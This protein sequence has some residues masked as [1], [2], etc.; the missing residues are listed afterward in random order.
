MKK[1]T[2]TSTPEP[3][4]VRKAVNVEKLVSLEL[5]EELGNIEY[6]ESRD[7]GTIYR[8]IGITW[9]EILKHDVVGFIGYICLK[10]YITDVVYSCIPY[11]ELGVSTF[12]Q[13]V[14]PNDES[15]YVFYKNV[16]FVDGTQYEDL[17][18]ATPTDVHLVEDQGKLQLQLEHDSEVLSIDEGVN[19]I[20]GRNFGYREVDAIEYSG[21]ITISGSL[22]GVDCEIT[23]KSDS[24]YFNYDFTNF[25]DNTTLNQLTA[26]N[27]STLVFMGSF[28][29][30]D[31]GA[32]ETRGGVFY[33]DE[34]GFH[35][36]KG[37]ISLENIM[38]FDIVSMSLIHKITGNYQEV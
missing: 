7:D 22:N 31:Y 9:D 14:I 38:R 25:D 29:Y 18:K 8:L 34:F 23:L 33:F 12:G 30:F 37:V 32:N 10:N 2:Y 16:S 5:S 1:R 13:Y 28:A 21:Y 11:D 4:Y 3:R 15:E 27:E 26:Q 19:D 35:D 24:M 6:Y 17:V 36:V 20:L